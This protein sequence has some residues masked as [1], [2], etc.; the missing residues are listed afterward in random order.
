LDS[1][2]AEWDVV[3]VCSVGVVGNVIVGVADIV[4]VASV[5]DWNLLT[6]ISDADWNILVV[7]SVAD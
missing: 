5:A 6:V 1:H 4:E 2:V 3:M 7:I